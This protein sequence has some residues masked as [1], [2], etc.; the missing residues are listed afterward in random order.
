[1]SGKLHGDEPPEPVPVERQS[2]ETPSSSD[3]QQLAISISNHPD[4]AGSIVVVLTNNGELRIGA[5]MINDPGVIEAM[6]KIAKALKTH[7]DTE[8]ERSRQ[9]NATGMFA[10]TERQN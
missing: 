10:D 5:G 3:A 2:D 6:G 8:W 7:C 1:M 4:V 9:K